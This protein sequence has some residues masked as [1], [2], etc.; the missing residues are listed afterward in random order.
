MNVRSAAAQNPTRV[1]GPLVWLDMDQKRARRRL[2]PGGLRAEP[3]HRPPAPASST[4]IA[5]RGALGAPGAS[6]TGRTEIEGSTCSRRERR[7]RRSTCS[8]TVAPGASARSR[9]TPS[10]RRPTSR[11]RAFHRARFRRRRDR[12]RSAADGRSGQPRHRLGLQERRELR[13]RSEPALHSRRSRRARISA[14]SW[15]STD[16]VKDYGLP[17]GPSRARCCAR[18]CTT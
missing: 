18:A 8:S 13:R 17:A 6:S 7:T 2:R 11:R 5:V 3:R 1:K 4:A 12:R 10:W 16:W 9:T 15:W 14:A